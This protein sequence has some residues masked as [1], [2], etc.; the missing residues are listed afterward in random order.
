VKGK[1]IIIGGGIIG[2]FSAYYL[3]QSGYQ[4]T[5]VDKSD[6]S[7]SCSYGNAGLVVPSHV[8]P[9]ASPGMVSAAMRYLLKPNAPVS[10]KMP[11]SPDFLHWAFRFLK[12]ANH[13]FVDDASSVLSE[14]TLFSQ[15]LYRAVAGKNQFPFHLNEKGLLIVCRSQRSVEEEAKTADLSNNL[16][17]TAKVLTGTELLK[18][19]PALSPDIPGGIYYPGDGNVVPNQLM[20]SLIDWI[21]KSGVTILRNSKLTAIHKKTAEI[22][23][24]KYDFDGLVI[25]AGTWSNEILKLVGSKVPLQPGR[26]YSFNLQNNIDIRY[27]ALLVDDRISVTPFPDGI[28][29][30]GGAMELGYFDRHIAGKRVNQMINSAKKNYASLHQFTMDDIQVWSGHRPCSFDGL[31]YIGR[32]PGHDQIYLATGHSMLGVTLA[33]ATGKLISELVNGESPS[34]NLHPLRVNR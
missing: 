2:L 30:F 8:V 1:I 21:E 31:P 14:L 17:V 16:G 33:P 19:E 15:S 18:M 11:P 27:P 5:I 13:A 4:V 23:K 3:H 10:I 9:L 29:R 6:L 7:D 24:E 20:K 34:V 25:A 32:V 12:T 28:T 22:N 26:G